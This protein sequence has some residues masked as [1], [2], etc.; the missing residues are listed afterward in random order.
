MVS[1][2]IRSKNTAPV[3]GR[4]QRLLISLLAVGILA[5][6]MSWAAV[7]Q[8]ET[9]LLEKEALDSAVKWD[10]FV[11]DNLSE[12]D[13]L[14]NGDPISANDQRVFEFASDAGGV[15]RF[16]VFGPAG[17]VVYA[18]R[19]SDLG[20]TNIKPYFDDV[21]KKGG[22]F[23]EIEDEEDFGDD[24]SVV[25]EAYVP[26]MAGDRFKG[27]I[28]VYVN[29]TGRA[30]ALRETGNYALA[31]LLLFM[32]VI[33]GICGLF[34]RRNILDR[35]RELREVV[36]SRERILVAEKKVLEARERAELANRAKSEFLA[37]MSHELRT[38]LNAV[39]GF[40]DMIC[41][42]TFGPVGSYKYREYV[43]HINW[44]G[45]HLLEIIN[46]I[47]DLSKI[48]AGGLTLYEETFDASSVIRSCLTLV[49]E[50]A[51][52]ADI[53]VECDIASDVPALRADKRMLKQILINLLSNAV[54]FTHAGGTITVRTW[55][56]ADDGYVFQIADTGAGIALED[57]PKAL[58]PFGQV[59][60]DLNRKHEGTGLGLPLTKAL[61]ELH[62]GSLV[63]HSEVG[64]GTTVTVR[65]P[66]DR[67]VLRAATGR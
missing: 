11:R 14:L 47:L 22:T 25:S 55:F 54:K 32:G 43:K 30:A 33:G 46:D 6:V 23:V 61:T 42:E 2:R 24:R 27:A 51:T 57:I 15:F 39:I 38:P 9:L 28:E 10:K 44:A 41:R 13:G 34:V 64:V 63:L 31:G 50:R 19:S 12:L 36:E 56:H 60:G 59:D 20:T 7:R 35:N 62:G 17:F 4:D 21:V 40:S 37:N 3:F 45:V 1:S 8:A 16:R 49:K 5:I 18:S 52:D 66:A 67:V 53:Q 65:F 58:T 48:E 26:I 29:M